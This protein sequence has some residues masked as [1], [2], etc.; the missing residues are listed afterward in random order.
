[1]P[2]SHVEPGVAEVRDGTENITSCCLFV[3]PDVCGPEAVLDLDPNMIPKVNLS[4]GRELIQYFAVI[5][6]GVA[7]HDEERGARKLRCNTFRDA[8]KS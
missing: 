2:A 6:V 7:V 4:V 1:M 5:A 8:V 3:A